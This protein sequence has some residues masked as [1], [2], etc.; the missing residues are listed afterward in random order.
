MHELF[1]DEL[2]KL[3]GRFMEMGINV[4]EQIYHAT[5]AFTKY[6]LKLSQEVIDEDSRIN[7]EEIYLEKEAL[8]LIAL[9][10]PV[11]TDFREIISVLKA[12][13]DLERI[14]DH[15]VNIA[16]EALNTGE[17]KNDAQI[18]RKIQS[19]ADDIRKM[20]ELTLDAY[21]V[22]DDQ[23]VRKAAEKDLEIDSQ[24]SSVRGMLTKSIEKHQT[25]AE[26][27]SS[28]LMVVRLLERIGDHIVNLAEWV[29]Y[30]KSGK[31]VELNLGKIRHQQ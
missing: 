10:Q 19:M 14:G 3:N 8:K 29:V 9:Q 25:T 11:A 31:I 15:A 27:G 28:Y 16:K 21:V 20:L 7:D 2:K 12:S 23:M 6:D 1:S 26:R 22:D 17:Q 18:E 4:S 30:N 13:S 24:Y 5:Q